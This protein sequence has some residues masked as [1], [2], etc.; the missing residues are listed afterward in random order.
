M[1]TLD[2]TRTSFST[3]SVSPV[4]I[5][6]EISSNKIK[7]KGFY[8]NWSGESIDELVEKDAIKK[9]MQ[10]G[11]PNLDKEKK[12]D[13]V[14]FI[15]DYL[16]INPISKEIERRYLHPQ[17]IM[18][19]LFVGQSPEEEKYKEASLIVNGVGVFE[20]IIETKGEKSNLSK[21][22]DYLEREVATLK[23]LLKEYRNEQ[24]NA[25]SGRF[26]IE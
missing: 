2:L 13:R 12:G 16:A 25:I 9:Y 18:S 22:V 11:T 14:F 1:K 23:A 3:K 21:K 6:D 15:L 17:R 7:I 8:P 10:I 19:R 26:D 24:I 5:N 4:N 20:K